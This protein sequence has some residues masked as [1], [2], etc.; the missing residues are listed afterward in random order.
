MAAQVTMPQIPDEKFNLAIP[1]IAPAI[2]WMGVIGNLQLALRHPKNVGPSRE[3]MRELGRALI[4]KLE[5]E[6]VLTRDQAQEAFMD[7][8]V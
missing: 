6:Q 7:F 2:V 8:F 4:G 5:D 3:L 1:V